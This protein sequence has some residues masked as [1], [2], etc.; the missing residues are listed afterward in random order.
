MCSDTVIRGWIQERPKLSVQLSSPLRASA[1][2]LPYQAACL[3][4]WPVDIQ[5]AWSWVLRSLG[6]G[7]VTVCPKAGGEMGHLGN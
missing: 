2:L 3:H 5:A 1:A 7:E 4:Q 6:M